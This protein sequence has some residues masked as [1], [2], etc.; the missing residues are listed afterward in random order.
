MA[1]AFHVRNI[2]IIL[3]IGGTLITPFL[4]GS[5]CAY[6]YMADNSNGHQA[7]NP[8]ILSSVL[9]CQIIPHPGVHDHDYH[10]SMV[11]RASCC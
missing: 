2:Y 11:H 6:Y 5:V 1:P 10:M 4:K 3:L 7:I 9:R 8:S